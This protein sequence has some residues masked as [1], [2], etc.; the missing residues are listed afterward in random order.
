MKNIVRIGL[1]VLLLVILSGCGVIHAINHP[2]SEHCL[3]P[4]YS[5]AID[6]HFMSDLKP[7][8]ALSDCDLRDIK[9]LTVKGL[10]QIK[11]R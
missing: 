9:L 2:Y 8:D 1:T 6:D 7:K 11:C 3:A 10:C 4:C 5:A